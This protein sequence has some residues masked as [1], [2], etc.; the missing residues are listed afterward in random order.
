MGKEE[1]G[2]KLKTQKFSYNFSIAK[3]ISGKSGTAKKTERVIVRM[4]VSNAIRRLLIIP[5]PG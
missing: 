3:F 4:S 2:K 1:E 5:L